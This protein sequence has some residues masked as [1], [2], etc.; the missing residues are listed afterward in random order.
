MKAQVKKKVDKTTRLIE[1]QDE[2]EKSMQNIDKVLKEQEEL[3]AFL[4]EKAEGKFPDLVNGLKES[5]EGYKKQREKLDIRYKNLQAVTLGIKVDAVKI[6][7]ES[8]LIA[9]GLEEND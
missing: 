5:N 6:L 3:I 9:L 1:M 2:I 4:E 8:L 7:V